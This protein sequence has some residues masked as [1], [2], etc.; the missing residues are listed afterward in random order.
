MLIL[1][2]NPAGNFGLKLR[3]SRFHKVLLRS[4]QNIPKYNIVANEGGRGKDFFAF[5]Y[6][7]PDTTFRFLGRDIIP[8]IMFTTFA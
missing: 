7:G 2:K 5:C 1:N 6:V 8:I 3:V 4:A